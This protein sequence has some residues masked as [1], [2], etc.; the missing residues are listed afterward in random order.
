M[1]ENVMNISALAPEPEQKIFKSALFGFKRDDVLTYIS[2]LNKASCDLAKELNTSIE[3]LENC[4]FVSKNENQELVSQA[5]KLENSLLQEASRAKELEDQV[6]AMRLEV[7]RASDE[8]A[9][10]KSQLFASSQEIAMLK[11]DNTRLNSSINVLTATIKDYEMQREESERKAEEILQQ[12]QII[13]QKALGDAKAIR[14]KAS[15][16]AVVLIAAAEKEKNEAKKTITSSAQNIAISV[17]TIKNEI[18]A[19]DAKIASAINELNCI[20]RNISNALS[21]TENNLGTLGVQLTVFPDSSEPV[22]A[23]PIKTV[24]QKQIRP[25]KRTDNV[26]EGILSRLAKLLR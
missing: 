5:Q 20:T 17:S 9:A 26:S 12:A 21:N 25:E 8:A 4:L 11:A 6:Q 19:V 18:N 14:D 3:K 23:K 2:T 7:D 10:N 1:A 13:K 15:D 16:E 24:Y 22:S